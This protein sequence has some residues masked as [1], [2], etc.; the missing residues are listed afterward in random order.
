[1]TVW[2][3]KD[4]MARRGVARA[5]ISKE[6]GLGDKPEERNSW[7]ESVYE[8]AGSDAAGVPWADLQPKDTLME[9]LDSLAPTEPRGRAID[10]ACGLGD[11]AE[12][13]ANAGFDTVAFDFSAKA[14]EWAKSRFPSSPVNY[15]V[16]DLLNSPAEWVGAF[17]FVHETYTVQAL[18]ED[19]RGGAIPAIANL[20]APGGRLLVIC[21]GR[22]D[23]EDI[24]GPPWPLD[25]LELSCFEKCG[26]ERVKFEDYMVVRDRPYSPF[27]GRVSQAVNLIDR[28]ENTIQEGIARQL[29]FPINK[30]KKSIKIDEK[31]NF[32]F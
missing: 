14:I 18:R 17:D 2:D 31:I 7:F 5:R 4:F 32:N 8:L 26:L 22:D 21:R 12:A 1:M 20:L 27:P 13:I 25:S 19:M 30:I 23:N 29:R 6:L 16:A 11:N 10:V 3:D 15:V 24:E 9:W 28:T